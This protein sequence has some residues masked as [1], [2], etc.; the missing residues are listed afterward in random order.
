MKYSDSPDTFELLPVEDVSSQLGPETRSW[1]LEIDSHVA[2][3]TLAL[4]RV[5]CKSQGP[6]QQEACILFLFWNIIF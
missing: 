6:V 5:Y 4:S 3:Y 2:P 1:K